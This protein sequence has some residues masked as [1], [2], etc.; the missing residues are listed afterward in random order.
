MKQ[1]E[2]VVTD[3]L[4]EIVDLQKEIE[5]QEDRYRALLKADE[6]LEKLKEVHLKIKYL[7]VELKAKENH[8]LA[9]FQSFDAL[10]NVGKMYGAWKVQAKTERKYSPNECNGTKKRIISGEP[11]DKFISTSYVERQNLNMRVRKAA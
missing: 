10:C 11:H 6:P 3:K 2:K 1:I 4:Q 5:L 9:L 7:K 8:A